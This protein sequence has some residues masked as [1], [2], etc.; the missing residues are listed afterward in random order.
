M[1]YFHRFNSSQRKGAIL[2]LALAG[3]IQCVYFFTHFNH[4]FEPIII[5]DYR[6]ELDSLRALA[7]QKKKDTI[8]PFNPNFIT[9]YKGWRLGMS[10]EEIDRLFAFREQGKWVNS[11]KEFQ[12]VTG[13]SDSL[14]A[15]IAPSFRFPDW[16]GKNRTY[17]SGYKQKYTSFNDK[18][19]PKIDINTA[20]K[21][22]LMKIYGIG[23][24]FSSRI[25]KYKEKLQGFTY[26]SQ[27]SEVYGL[28]KEVYQRV[29]E[30]FEVKNP[31]VI[32]KKDI[33]K[34]SMYD[35]S[36]IPYIKYGEGKKIVALRSELG[37][38]KS[39]EDLLQIEGFDK[40][41]IERLQLYLYIDVQ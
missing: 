19:L 2:L 9:D 35:L 4:T 27:V 23:E 34:L 1:R 7:L 22:E 3:I 20:T 28:D 24:G 13:I 38:I 11:A 6:R 8:Y 21:E 17:K 31:P 33:N 32:E 41:R 37:N 39:F 16:V 12:Q 40:Q 29:A 30:R 26:I 10:P 14:L 18:K 36:K 15:K 25:L 5:D